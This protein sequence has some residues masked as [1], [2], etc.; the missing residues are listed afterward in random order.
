MGLI[1]RYA[2]TADIDTL[3]N[4]HAQSL[5]AA[6]KDIIPYGILDN[7]F[8]V[9]RRRAGFT[10]E[11]DKK[12]P[13]NAIAFDDENPIGLL[14]FGDSRYIDVDKE[15]TEL[16]RIY[17]LPKYWGK[18]CGEEL[19]NW[20][21]NEIKTRG[22]KKVIL[23]VLEENLRARRF[24]EKNGFFHNGQRME[25]EMGKKISELLYIRNL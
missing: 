11:L 10:R 2:N 15:T 22:F 1:I 12:R 6:Y 19:F 5:R 3:A 4:V 18:D 7:D 24:Y 21:I 23:W 20:G 17:L 13:F 25:E 9:E 8:S 14:S 16:W